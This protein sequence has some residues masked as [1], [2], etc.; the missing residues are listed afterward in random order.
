MEQGD[1]V[2]SKIGGETGS[3]SQLG[4]LLCRGAPFFLGGLPLLVR[5]TLEGRPFSRL[6]G[7]SGE[8]GDTS[9]NRGYFD[10]RTR[11]KA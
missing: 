10:T 3:L 8:E 4:L 1:L 6:G 2:P 7:S 5:T 11:N 9:G